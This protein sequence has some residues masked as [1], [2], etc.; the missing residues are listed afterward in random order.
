MVAEVSD[1]EVVF[2][3]TQHIYVIPDSTMFEKRG[4]QYPYPSSCGSCGGLCI[5][6]SKTFKW[7]WNLFY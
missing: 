7:Q 3:H 2:S 5:T 4:K 1:D 6:C